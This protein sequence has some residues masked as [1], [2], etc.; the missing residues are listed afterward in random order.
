MTPLLLNSA[1]KV[2]FMTSGSGKAKA[3]A[4]VLEDPAAGYPAKR[5]QP[6]SGHLTWMVGRAAAALLSHEYRKM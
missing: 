1:Q 4:G 6:R 5:F 2:I 3:L